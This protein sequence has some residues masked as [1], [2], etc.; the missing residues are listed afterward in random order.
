MHGTGTH[1]SSCPRVSRCMQHTLHAVTAHRTHAH[2]T[3]A[4]AVQLPGM[5]S[6]ARGSETTCKR[7]PGLIST[8]G[9]APIATGPHGLTPVPIPFL[10]N[11]KKSQTSDHTVQLSPAC[12]SRPAPNHGAQPSHIIPAPCLTTTHLHSLHE[13]RWRGRQQRAAHCMERH[14]LHQVVTHVAHANP[15]CVCA[16]GQEVRTSVWSKHACGQTHALLHR[17]VGLCRAATQL[18]Q[19]LLPPGFPLPGRNPPV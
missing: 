4:F 19:L 5:A 1:T 11:P 2:P 9:V 13:L 15:S 16:G 7:A 17:M 3:C 18:S 8:A 10:I 6:A 14:R 12:R